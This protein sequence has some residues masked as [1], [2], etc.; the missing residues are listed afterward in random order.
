MKTYKFI[1]ALVLFIV[2][3]YSS[4]ARA[5]TLPTSVVNRL[6]AGAPNWPT[7]TDGELIDYLESVLVNNSAGTAYPA[8]VVAAGDRFEDI[9]PTLRTQAANGGLADNTRFSLNFLKN[10]ASQSSV[11]YDLDGT[12]AANM[13]RYPVGGFNGG[14]SY[15]LQGGITINPTEVDQS[16]EYLINHETYHMFQGYQFNNGISLVEPM[17]AGS[18]PQRLASEVM[19]NTH[20]LQ[21][22][23]QAFF[24]TDQNYSFF[25]RGTP[26]SPPGFDNV[27][28]VLFNQPGYDIAGGPETKFN[29]V[30]DTAEASGPNPFVSNRA[31]FF[32][33]T[34]ATGVLEEVP[35]KIKQEWTASVTENLTKYDSEV[36]R[37]PNA[38]APTAES[39]A[40][41]AGDTLSSAL[42]KVVTGVE[43]AAG[44]A[45]EFVLVTAL[46][47]TVNYG[48]TLGAERLYGQSLY[49]DGNSFVQ[50]PAKYALFQANDDYSTHIAEMATSPLQPP[51]LLDYVMGTADAKT[52]VNGVVTWM[53][54]DVNSLQASIQT[55]TQSFLNYFTGVTEQDDPMYMEK[56]AHMVNSLPPVAYDADLENG[57]AAEYASFKSDWDEAHRVMAAIGQASLNGTTTDWLTNSVLPDDHALVTNT[58]NPT[59]LNGLSNTFTLLSTPS[60]PS[61]TIDAAAFY[62]LNAGQQFD[63][64]YSGSTVN[65][66]PIPDSATFSG[67]QSNPV[68]TNFDYG[69][70]AIASPIA[71]LFPSYKQGAG[72]TPD[73][74]QPMQ[75]V[76]ITVDPTV[77]PDQTYTAA[78]AAVAGA[79]TG[80]LS[81]LF[82]PNGSFVTDAPGATTRLGSDG[83]DNPSF[84]DTV[85]PDTDTSFWGGGGDDDEGDS[86]WD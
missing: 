41:E 57:R 7:A 40:A 2:G 42:S 24:V 3:A 18:S 32:L 21:D 1:V 78:N 26:K 79:F 10:E 45:G 86:G 17:A 55:N 4:Q 9:I 54:V 62:N 6:Y 68:W 36:W 67:V 64:S 61:Y 65:S 12:S 72:V 77:Y 13:A 35:T 85:V 33:D 82:N 39:L 80:Q 29:F 71:P 83:S 70:T 49:T 19:A 66:V 46:I 16:F 69:S 53:G 44:A 28:Q 63:Y 56:F 37:V 34:Q 51:S 27:N 14:V 30:V 50:D 74:T 25:G 8:D 76:G 38:V 23:D 75:Q 81:L 43:G 58:V 84:L 60:T 22:L 11:I 31:Q 15:Q 5:A 47:E 20:A 52:I 48:V 73:L 59:D